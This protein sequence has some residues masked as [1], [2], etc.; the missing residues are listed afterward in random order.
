M[1]ISN[2]KTKTLTLT[3]AILLFTMLLSP[4]NIWLASAA[5]ITSCSTA[6]GP[7]GVT[8]DS[9]SS[10]IW[11]GESTAGKISSASVPSS[12]T[13]CSTTPYTAQHDPTRV[14]F[15]GGGGSIAF[16]QKG[17]GGSTASCITTFNTATHAL[18]NSQCYD[19]S[20]G[21]TTGG[22][23]DDVA[24]D[25]TSSTLVWASLYYVGKIAKYDT[26]SG[27][28]SYINVPKAAGCVTTPEPEGLRVDSNGN[29]WV[30]DEACS[31]I[32]EYQPGA[33]GFWSS[34]LPGYTPSFL[35]LDNTNSYVWATAPPYNLIMKINMNS[36]TTTTAADPST[37]T[38]P[39][40]IAA[41]PANHRVDVTFQNGGSG[42]VDLYSTSASGWLCGSGGDV[43]TGS[44]PFGIATESPDYYWATDYNN[45][46]LL[47]GDC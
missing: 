7:K 5:K 17:T 13:S 20:H 37:E 45:A 34:Y 43:Y 42:S 9:S 19:T 23:F 24:Q 15:S 46:K 30:A 3:F 40:V 8:M 35:D 12:P 18:S 25:P 10:N 16:T 11:I 41:D 38:T 29:V 22:G 1:K 39:L 44:Y 21:Q 26:S 32:E 4:T 2:Q 27:T 28:I 31:S 36:G 47:V 33:G 6:T 14:A